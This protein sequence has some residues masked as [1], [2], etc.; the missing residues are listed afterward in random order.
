MFND[1]EKVIFGILLFVLGIFVG[2]STDKPTASDLYREYEKIKSIC[3]VEVNFV[4]NRESRTGKFICGMP[5][6]VR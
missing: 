6:G 3:S 1:T 2:V 5:G 4:G